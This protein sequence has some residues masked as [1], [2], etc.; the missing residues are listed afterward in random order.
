MSET[1]GDIV[2]R[3]ARPEDYEAVMD[4]DRNMY[5]GTD[6]L[7]SKYHQYLKDPNRHAYVCESDGNV[8]KIA[9]ICL[10]Y[11]STSIFSS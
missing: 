11:F 2:V 9:Y 10:F 5:N 4:I 8:V 7:P 6:Y 3:K 1:R